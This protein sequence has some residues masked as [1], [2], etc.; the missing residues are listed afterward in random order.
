MIVSYYDIEQITDILDGKFIGNR[1]D[2]KIKYLLIDSRKIL[3]AQASLFFALRGER[4]DG[5]EYIA[6]L[7][8][9]GVRCFVVSEKVGNKIGRAHV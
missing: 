3:H 5:H 2:Y 8:D 7:Y 1:T 4:H 9:K 6:E